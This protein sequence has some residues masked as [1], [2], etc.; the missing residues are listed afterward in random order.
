[1]QEV[2]G[3]RPHRPDRYPGRGTVEQTAIMCSQQMQTSASIT[4][5][6]SEIVAAMTLRRCSSSIPDSAGLNGNDVTASRPGSRSQ[7][8]ADHVSTAA[9]PLS[10]LE[11]KR[12]QEPA[13]AIG[14]LRGA[15]D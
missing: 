3:I 11:Q 8:L 14:V 4:E 6:R 1:M 15:A 2:L 9:A 10:R 12:R 13:A 7:F 5:A